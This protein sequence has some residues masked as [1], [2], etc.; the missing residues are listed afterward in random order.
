MK[1]ILQRLGE[2]KAEVRA[3]GTDLNALEAE[4]KELRAELEAI[5]VEARRQE[6]LSIVDQTGAIVRNFANNTEETA[7]GIE[8]NEYRNAFFKHLQRKELTPAEERAFTSADNSAG[9]LIPTSTANSIMKKLKEEAPLLNEITLLNATGQLKFVV[10]NEVEDASMHTENAKITSSTDTFTTVILNGYEIVKLIQVSDTVGTMS[11]SAFETWLVDM[12]VGKIASKVGTFLINGTGSSQPQGIEKADT[13]GATNSVTVAKDGTLTVA[14]V[15]AF[16][17]MLGDGYAKTGKI[18]MKRTT[19]FN[20]F[21]PLQDKSKND[22]VTF[23]G[24]KYYVYGIEVMLDGAVKEHEAYFGAFKYVIGNLAENM[25]IKSQY[26]IDTNS[27]KYLGV[28]IFDSK[29]AV[30]EAFV[31]LIKAT[32]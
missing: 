3:E 9:V 20:D 28:C 29:V 12:L 13:W 17:G 10:E 14:N 15:L 27:N 23:S 26:D 19:L 1:E 30:S 11:I 2:I 21:M 7:P 22:I 16:I 18:L 31:K 32:A 4:A 6:T 24:G 5:E 8:S 25:T